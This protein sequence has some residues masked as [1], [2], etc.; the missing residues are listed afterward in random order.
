MIDLLGTVK[1]NGVRAF[2]ETWLIGEGIEFNLYNAWMDVFTSSNVELRYFENP[3]SVAVADL[4]ACTASLSDSLRGALA[5]LVL[6]LASPDHSDNVDFG[7]TSN[8]VTTSQL[9]ARATQDVV[10]VP[11]I[12]YAI[13]PAYN[14]R[15]LS[16][17]LTLQIDSLILIIPLSVHH[18]CPSCWARVLWCST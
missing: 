4:T 15:F 9:S 14:V 10:Q 8:M 16:T 18:R 7:G 12:A 11:I 13:G 17:Q 3:A 1:C 2:A 5:A 6:T